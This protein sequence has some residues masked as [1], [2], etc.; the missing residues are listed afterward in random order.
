MLLPRPVEVKFISNVPS[1][2]MIHVEDDHRIA[3]VNSML[4]KD[5]KMLR[6]AVS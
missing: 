4:Q 6:V 2:F 1:D 5:W 3:L